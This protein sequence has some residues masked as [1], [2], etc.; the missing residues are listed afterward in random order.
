MHICRGRGG[1]GVSHQRETGAVDV[2]VPL[3]IT[4]GSLRVLPPNQRHHG[5]CALAQAL[6]VWLVCS[7]ADS[8]VVIAREVLPCASRISFFLRCTRLAAEVRQ[9]RREWLGGC[10]RTNWSWCCGT[11][12][13]TRAHGHGRWCDRCV[14]ARRLCASFHLRLMR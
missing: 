13:T 9:D 11:Y 3:V 14:H 10:A 7:V 4:L 2:R 6:P 1:G 12:P 8:C 5:E